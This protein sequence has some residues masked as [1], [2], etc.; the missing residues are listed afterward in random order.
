LLRAALIVLT[1]RASSAIGTLN[2]A[3]SVLGLGFAAGAG[4]R[5]RYPFEFLWETAALP[6]FGFAAAAVLP[7]PQTVSPRAFLTQS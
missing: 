4:F 6:V 7:L 1:F 5:G 2:Y 3:L